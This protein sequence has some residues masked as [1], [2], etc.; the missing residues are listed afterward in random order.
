MSAAVVLHSEDLDETR[1]VVGAAFCPHTLELPDRSTPL[2][3]HYR[4]HQ[5]DDIGVTV[6]DY[7][8]PVRITTPRGSDAFLVEIPLGGRSTIRNGASTLVAD[9]T[10]GPSSRWPTR[11]T[12]SGRRAARSSSSGSSAPPST[13]SCAP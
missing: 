6:L 12:R 10:T 8:A 13:T 3:V 2:A 4:A 1:D 7:G 11:S 9:R 5:V